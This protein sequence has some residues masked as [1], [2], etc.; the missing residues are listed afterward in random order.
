MIDT[1][2]FQVM[3]V[4]DLRAMGHPEFKSISD[5]RPCRYIGDRE[6]LV[7]TSVKPFRILGT[8]GGEV[9]DQTLSRDWRWVVKELNALD[10]ENKKKEVEDE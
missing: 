1:Q 5:V 3:W 9:E 6:A 4:D 2:R 10:L 7:D 8:D